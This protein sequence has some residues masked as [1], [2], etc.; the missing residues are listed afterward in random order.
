MDSRQWL[1]SPKSDQTEQVARVKIGGS[2]RINAKFGFV[3]NIVG[4][5]TIAYNGF[6][7][8]L[9]IPIPM[10]HDKFCLTAGNTEDDT[11][12]VSFWVRWSGVEDGYAHMG[13]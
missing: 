10:N 8:T 1:E 13:P 2:L 9:Y 5:Y 6:P 12:W 3:G 4:T 7:V 11:N